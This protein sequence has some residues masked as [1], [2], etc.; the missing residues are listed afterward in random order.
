MPVTFEKSCVS[1]CLRLILCL[2]CQIRQYVFDNHLVNIANTFQILLE[3]NLPNSNGMINDNN[4][5]T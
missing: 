1:L 2:N 5:N 3:I 4:R